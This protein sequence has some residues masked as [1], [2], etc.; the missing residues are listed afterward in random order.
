MD[1]VYVKLRMRN[2]KNKYRKMLSTDEK[3]Y[4]NISEM[5]E[6]SYDYTAGA[7]LESGEW[8]KIE[9]ASQQSFAIDLIQQNYASLDFETLSRKDFPQIDYIF[10]KS[11]NELCFQN[12][13]KARLASKKRLGSFGESFSYESDSKEII[14][15]S[16]FPHHLV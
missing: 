15:N 12:V 6:S 14:I 7:N 4:A 9:N 10:V 11:G 2:N 1:T 8:F 13:S 5:I 3:I 16:N